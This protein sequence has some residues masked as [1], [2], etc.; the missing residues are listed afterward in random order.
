MTVNLSLTPS[1]RKELLEINLDGV[2]PESTAGLVLAD[3]PVSHILFPELSST[4]SVLASSLLPRRHHD[5][6]L[7]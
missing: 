1:K 3:D 2:S 6:K 5:N 7:S 4:S